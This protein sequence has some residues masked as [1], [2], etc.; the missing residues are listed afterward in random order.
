MNPVIGFN[1]INILGLGVTEE[2]DESIYMPTVG[3][4]LASCVF[5]S[6]IVFGKVY[7]M[8]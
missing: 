8:I 2:I 5:I 6:N 4:V 3:F 1:G 7:W